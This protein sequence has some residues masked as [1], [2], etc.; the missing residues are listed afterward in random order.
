MPGSKNKNMKKISLILSATILCVYS[1]A[2]DSSTQKLDELMSA[3]LNVGRFNGSVLIAK[4]G[5]I[6]LEKGYGVKNAEEK[7]VNDVSTVFQIA[8]VTKQFTATVILKLVEQKKMI[9]GDKLSKYYTGFPNGDSISIENLLN[10]T[11]GL[12]NFTEGDTTISETDERRMVSYLKTLKPDFAPGSKWHYSNSG[13]VMLGYIIQKVSGMSYWQAVRKYIFDPLQ[14]NNS[15][16]DF[17]HL[18]NN[19]K[20]VGYDV[21]ND[22]LRQRSDIT[23]STVPFAAGSIYSTVEDMYKWHNGLQSYKVVA[24]TLMDKAYTACSLNNYGYGWQIDSVFGKRMVSHSGSISGFGSNFA[25][26]PE[27][28]ICIILLSNK[29]GSTFDLM[30]ITNKLL[31]ILYDQPYSIPVKRVAVKLDSETLK[32]YTGT[33]EITELQLT[34]DVFINDG[35]LIAQPYRDSMPGPTSVML[36]TDDKRF[37]G[38]N[39]E[40]IEIAFETDSS[41]KTIGVNIIQQGIKRYAKK[42]K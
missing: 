34:I 37:Y 9:L 39:D 40:E 41:G 10:H 36:A 38:R 20:A 32:R 16:F 19:E 11:S 42:T 30:N 25:R 5:R 35:L 2:Q 12:H 29:A 17:T 1:F 13:Y 8:S 4:H 18:Q 26:I 24:K 3:Y 14:M 7:S 31:A 15:G 21:L 6:L 28:D 27:D 22:S 23:D 33:Y